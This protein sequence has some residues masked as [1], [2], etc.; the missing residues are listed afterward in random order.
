MPKSSNYFMY[1]LPKMCNNIPKDYKE[2]SVMELMSSI[3]RM[4]SIREEKGL[5]MKEAAAAPR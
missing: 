2:V 1:N 5:N 3:N 4:K